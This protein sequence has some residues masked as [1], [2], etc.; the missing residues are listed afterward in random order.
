MVRVR[1]ATLADAP[2]LLEIYGHYCLT[3]RSTSEVVPPPL[4]EFED[5]IRHVLDY[6]PYFVA[7]DEATNRIAG[8]A[9]ASL[10]GPGGYSWTA[11]T[12]IYVD[13]E[14]RNQHI[15]TILYERLLAALKDQH[16]VAAFA[17]LTSPNEDS[18]RF[19][20]RNGFKSQM[21]LQLMTYKLGK[22]LGQSIMSIDLNP[23]DKSPV[24]M[25][26]FRELDSAKYVS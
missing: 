25:I 18:K 14:F 1:L 16:F 2:R 20:E 8:Y 21:E 12:S 7:E 3:H 11:L 23:R 13:H 17:V 19:H 10:W 26:P 24:A 4:E 6:F 9:Y 5:R 22:W 15:G